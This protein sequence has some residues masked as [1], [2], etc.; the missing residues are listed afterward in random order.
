[1]DQLGPKL[2]EA[3]AR[4]RGRNGRLR[5]VKRVGASRAA[6][7][8][9]LKEALVELADE[10][11]RGTVHPDSSFGHVTGLWLADVAA[12]VERGDR[13][14]KT[15][16]DYRSAAK[17]L[18]S[19]MGDLS[20][21]EVTAGQCDEV[22]KDVHDRSGPTAAKHAKK[23][24]SG[25]CGF[26]VRWGAMQV[27]PALSVERLERKPSSPV[28]ALEPGQRGDFLTKLRVFTGEKVR[29][30]GPA[31]GR[32]WADLPD[33]AEVMLAT[34]CRI[35]EALALVGEDVDIAERTVSAGHHLVRVPGVGM[36]RQEKRKGGREGLV[37]RVPSWA[38]PVLRR[39][40]LE[41]GGGP[42]FPTYLGTWLDPVNVQKR[43]RVACREIGYE[44]VTSH[45][46]RHTT[47]TH[48]GDSDLSDE[49]ISDALGN[50]PDVVRKHY[51]RKK[52]DPRVAEAL[53]GLMDQ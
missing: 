39:R 36:V 10:V 42:L 20:C 41:S 21:R 38:V 45:L 4:F 47:A 16:S 9:A 46:F 37:L 15:L 3:H 48:L 14:P 31:K 11:A 8:R 40:K 43:L 25:V 24:L 12:K 51:R 27:N 5:P 7:E 30:Q 2:F 44:G 34:G 33:L 53:E 18:T 35:G 50:T 23:V 29:K 32:A 49:V 19:R 13:A 26:A 28:R 52:S 22:L 17:N 6:A 1:M